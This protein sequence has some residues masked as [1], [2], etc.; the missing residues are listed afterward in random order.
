MLTE[1]THRHRAVRPVWHFSR[2]QEVIDAK[3][4]NDD[5]N[6]DDNDGRKSTRDGSEKS[7]AENPDFR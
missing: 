1:M 2:V 6:E 3:R 7:F 5:D 4:D